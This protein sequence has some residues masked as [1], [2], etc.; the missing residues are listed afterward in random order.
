MSNEAR[1]NTSLSRRAFVA[2][3][4][5]LLSS[6]VNSKIVY[7][8][9]PSIASVQALEDALAELS[10]S[11][12]YEDYLAFA[13]ET[14]IDMPDPQ[15]MT[16][17]IG[18]EPTVYASSPYWSSNDN[19][20]KTCYF[21]NGEV[22]LQEAIRVIDVSVHNGDIN[23]TSVQ[24]AGIDAA[25]LRLGYGVGN[26]DRKFARNVTHCRN[27]GMPFGVYLYSY[28]Y[29]AAFARSE[30]GFVVSVLQKYGL[31]KDM[32]VFYDLEKW[33]WKGHTPPTSSSVYEQIVRTF[34]EVLT[35]A[36]YTN[37]H[38]YSYKNYLETLLN[39]S[40][41]RQRASWVAQYNSQLNYDIISTSGVKGWQYTSTGRVS[42]INGNVDINAFSV[43]PYWTDRMG[44]YG[45]KD[46]FKATPHQS[47]IGWLVEKGISTGFEDGTF[48][49]YSSIAR[50]DMAAFLYRLAGS[51]AYEPAESERV[52]FR[53]VSASTPHSNEVLWLASTGVSMGYEDGTFRPYTSVARCDMAAF[54]HRFYEKVGIRI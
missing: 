30:A 5:F 46:V 19:G 17:A 29:D 48:R 41:I 42:G 18:N 54:L 26:E 8:E 1:A 6:A 34:F 13:E 40:Y 23:W 22:F 47:D 50:C 38:V 24:N 52:K 12:T 33:T 15:G 25:I 43:V 39:T 14:L 28:A 32:P 21:G 27:V 45:F 44:I 31:D 7:A 10:S 35:N 2:A 20:V 3:S 37:V 51:P 16:T 49:P 53:D 9:E 36:G 4:T 11:A